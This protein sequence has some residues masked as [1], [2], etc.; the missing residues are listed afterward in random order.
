MNYDVIWPD[1]MLLDLATFWV[2]YPNQAEITAAH[3]EIDC[4]LRLAPM[5][6]GHPVSEGLWR[7]DRHPLA[8]SYTI[9]T[10][11]NSVTVSHI[12]YLL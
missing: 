1:E 8:V 11:A 2:T 3:A 10:Q 7:I 9:D 5:T 6:K 4:L 12:G